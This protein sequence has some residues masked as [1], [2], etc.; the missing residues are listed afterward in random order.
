MEKYVIKPSLQFY[1][2]YEVTGKDKKELTNDFEKDEEGNSVKVIQNVD[3]F[4]VTTKTIVKYKRSNGTSYKDV[5]V[6]EATYPEGTKLVY[7]K[8]KGYVLAEYKMCTV[9]EAIEDLSVLK[10]AIQ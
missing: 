2:V 1:V 7:V 8:N 3:G 6:E 5:D 4:K 10:E 9:D